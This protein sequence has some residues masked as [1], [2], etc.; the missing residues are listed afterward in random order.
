ME[1]EA[2]GGYRLIARLG[3]GGMADVFLAVRNGPVGFTKLVVIKRLRADLAELPQAPR[4]RGLLLDEAR[5]AARMHHPH[6]VQT[7]EVSEQGGEPYLAMEYLDGQA[8]SHV[9]RAARRTEHPVP[10]DLALRIMDDILSALAY[11][12]DLADYDGEP[13]QI[14]HRDISP[15]NIFWTYEGEIKL[16]DFGVAKFALGTHETQAG[17][18][19]GKLAYMAPEQA[20]GEPLDRRADL[21]AAGIVLWEL[22][23]NRRLLR[24]ANDAASLQRLLFEP[25]PNL[26]DV[27]ADVDP[28][29]AAIAARALERDPDARYQSAAQMRADLA[30][31]LGN[32][33]QREE[34]AAFIAPLF[35]TERTDVSGQ[36]RR[37]MSGENTGAHIVT[38]ASE[39]LSTSHDE[40]AANETA[41]V[42]GRSSPRITR[43][44]ATSPAA[45]NITARVSKQAVAADELDD[46][47]ARASA[48]I[49]ARASGQHQ[50]PTPG[51]LP[52]PPPKRSRAP[53]LIGLGIAILAVVGVDLVFLTSR[54]EKPAIAASG[55]GSGS[56]SAAA[57]ATGSGSAAVEKTVHDFAKEAALRLCGSNTV[58]A[59]LG[60]ALVDE[61]LRQKGASDVKQKIVGKEETL[62]SATLDGAP[63]TV[64]IQAQ[65]TATAFEGLTK[66]ACDIGMAS[67]QINDKE[68]AA[69]Q[70][71]GDGDLRSP[72]TEHVIAL[73][74]I[75]VIV[76]PNNRIRALDRAALHDIFVGKV[77]DWSA[78]GGA[79]GPITVLARDNNSGT[80]DTFKNLV[81]GKGENVP[82]ATRRFA[83]S[84][85]LADTV[86]SD[87]T[88]IGFIGLAYV[89]SAKAIAVGDPGTVPKLP[90]S[91]TVTTEGYMLSRRLYFY[92][93]PKPRT[94]LVA[95]LVSFALSTQ[96]QA[97]AQKAGFIDLSVTLAS[98]ASCDAKCPPGYAAAIAHAQ[99]VSLDFRF[100]PGSDQLDSRATRDLDRIVQFLRGYPDGKL[101]LFGFSD[102]VGAP[103]VNAKLSLDRAKTIA[104]ELATRG[105]KPALVEG[106]GAALPVAPNTTEA[107]RLRNRRVEVWLER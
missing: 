91:F 61:F 69:L 102:A 97:V 41:T 40:L 23:A 46:A 105:V 21:F 48:R 80:F 56:G 59:E 11:A 3:R 66:A 92:S 15:Q 9:V 34:L 47:K 36:I 10:T 79:P 51:E 2:L 22:I 24:A 1:P 12:H 8:L 104:D 38:L 58:G 100:Q 44:G 89:R 77:T 53:L 81:L 71:I 18:I 90:T 73:D 6:I 68:V 49:R 95:E 4:F 65:G 45:Q 55:T 50:V 83:A 20:R 52:P 57:I 64:D 14:V 101:L 99:R 28:R 75:A 26:V 63:I 31:I 96:G 42:L 54:G 29:I 13:L 35:E 106:L 62:V 78:V 39:E 27:R 67:R 76:H 32:R 72:A 85:N 103:A 60:P 84:D 16:M 107:D 82:A 5:L 19:K 7:F 98:T 43:I 94:P 93:T 33:V 37:A 70:A 17:H 25:L 88:A 87:P 74:G 86:A 30:P